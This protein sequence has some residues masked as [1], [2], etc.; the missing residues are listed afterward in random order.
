MA[1]GLVVYQF[2]GVSP[3]SLETCVVEL[4][5]RS[6]QA[7][8]LSWLWQRL[9]VR[10]SPVSKDESSFR[11]QYVGGRKIGFAMVGTLHRSGEQTSV[12]AQLVIPMYYLPLIGFMF[13]YFTAVGGWSGFMVSLVIVGAIAFTCVWEIY[14]LGN[15]LKKVLRIETNNLKQAGMF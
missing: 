3:L 1:E 5:N 7:N 2:E 12:Q 8:A 14:R 9:S 15:P 10:V 6:E 4:Q 11:M 13:V